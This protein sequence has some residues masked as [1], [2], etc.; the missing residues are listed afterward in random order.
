MSEQ[1]R[2]A[3]ELGA[4]ERGERGY[5]IA[6]GSLPAHPVAALVPRPSEEEYEE[7][8]NDIEARGQ[9]VPAITY[10][11]QLID[12]LTRERACKEL[13]RSL[14]V[15]EWQPPTDYFEGGGSLVAFIVSVNSRRRHLTAGQKAALALAALPAA[16]A[17]MAERR[18]Q[19]LATSAAAQPRDGS[20][21]FAPLPTPPKSATPKVVSGGSSGSGPHRTAEVV[22]KAAGVRRQ[23]VDAVRRIA[24]TDAAV[25]AAVREGKL[26]VSAGIALTEAPVPVRQKVLA[27][28]E[29][30]APLPSPAAIR[31]AAVLA[32]QEQASDETGRPLHPGAVAGWKSLRRV[33]GRVMRLLREADEAWTEERALSGR[34]GA[35]GSLSSE[36]HTVLSRLGVSAAALRSSMP[37]AVCPYCRG[38]SCEDGKLCKGCGTSGFVTRRVFDAAPE[39]FRDWEASV[40]DLEASR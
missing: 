31:R 5:H 2:A 30:G 6:P 10:R 17:E 3:A 26:P 27:D 20:S 35:W 18:R 32:A 21:R 36:A 39:D 9:H 24:A 28:A 25:F 14:R 7:L 38:A 15:V 33:L 40:E 8:R 4:A 11:G 13:G 16:E 22:A 29:S 34:A 23:T 12:G 19:R 1:Q 37:Y